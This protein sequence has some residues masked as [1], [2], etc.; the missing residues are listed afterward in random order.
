VVPPFL[1]R[2]ARPLFD[3]GVGRHRFP[4]DYGGL[5][6]FHLCRNHPVRLGRTIWAQ[7]LTAL[8]PRGPRQRFYLYC[9]Y[10][11]AYETTHSLSIILLFARIRDI[12]L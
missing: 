12:F 11:W 8:I 10:F 2:I 3:S 9:I 7:S 5:P 1:S 6:G 4:Y